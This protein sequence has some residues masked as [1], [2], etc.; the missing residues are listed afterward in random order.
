[1]KTDKYELSI[2]LDSGHKCFSSSELWL[3][4]VGKSLQQ[5]SAD[6]IQRMLHG[7]LAHLLH[8]SLEF[9]SI[10]VI[11]SSQSHNCC[12]QKMDFSAHPLY[13]PYSV[14]VMCPTE[15]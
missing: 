9:H 1:M 13:F 8:P 4:M 5:I 2:I 12:L 11:I 3:V 14:M 7:C 15:I 6:T 10:S